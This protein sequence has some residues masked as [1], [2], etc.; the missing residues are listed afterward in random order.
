MEEWHAEAEENGDR[1]AMDEAAREMVWILETWGR[2]ELA[3]RLEYR[4]ASAC[5]EQMPLAF[6]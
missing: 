5:D 6:E 2:D 4:R 3:R 1:A